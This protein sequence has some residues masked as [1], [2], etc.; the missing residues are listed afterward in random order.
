MLRD[1]LNLLIAYA[2]KNLKLTGLNEIFI[3]NTLMKKF[4]LDEEYLETDLSIIDP[5]TR[6]DLLIDLLSKDLVEEGIANEDD[7][8]L[9]V[10]EIFGDLSLSPNEFLSEFNKIK[11]LEGKEKA[12]DF[13]YDYNIKN[14][15]IQKTSIEKNILWDDN[16]LEYPIE[17]SINLSKPEKKNSDIAKLKMMKSTSYPKCLLC[18]ENLGFYGDYKRAPRRTIRFIPVTLDGERWYL[19]YSPYGYYNK[20]AICFSEN[21]NDM[22]INKSTF[23]KLLDFVSQYPSFFM[24]SN[25]DLPIVGGSILNHEHFQGGD[26]VLPIFKS[27]DKCVY[28]LNKY[29]DLKVSNLKWY[30]SVIKIVGEDIDRIASCANDLLQTFRDY[31]DENINLISKT[32][33]LHSTI[34]PIARCENGKYALY[35]I[36][37][38]NRTSN[39]H[40][41][42]IFH[43]HKEYHHIKAE[44]IGL[45]EAMGLFILP[46]RLKKELKLARDVLT[47]NISLA[48]IESI[49]FMNKHLDMIKSLVKD[50]GINNDISKAS[51]LIKNYLNNVCKNILIN[52][53]VFKDDEKG[54]ASLLNLIKEAKL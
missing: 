21:H 41:D 7:V 31:N 23:K 30:N 28:Q 11:E 36:L 42:G 25:A 37:R 48:E 20:H 44:G 22:V 12:L 14:N 18:K 2:K 38:N 26:H 9:L 33:A 10:D 43:A 19:Q 15:Y 50:N 1:D 54:N 4:N 53:A 35:L 32:D 45:I 17:M 51:L 6:P 24:G 47:S 16:S 29:Q 40:P 39:I 27:K 5:L 8:H 3:R 52:T 46:A 34:T 13:F 49:D